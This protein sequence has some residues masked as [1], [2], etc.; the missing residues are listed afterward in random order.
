MNVYSKYLLSNLASVRYI[1]S[2]L[3]QFHFQSWN[4]C[5]F[6]ASC[7]IP[8][9]VYGLNENNSWSWWGLNIDHAHGYRPLA[10]AIDLASSGSDGLA[11]HWQ[12][13]LMYH[14]CT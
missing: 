1:Y 10:H 6:Q 14:F 8:N 5:V 7:K 3:S 11:A 2:I 4:Y 12:V 13:G 9:I